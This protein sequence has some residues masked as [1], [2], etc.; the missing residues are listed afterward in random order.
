M[1]NYRPV[2]I[3][4]ESLE[5]LGQKNSTYF[6]HA[7]TTVFGPLRPFRQARFPSSE[8]EETRINTTVFCYV[9]PK[10]PRVRLQVARRIVPVRLKPGQSENAKASALDRGFAKI[11][12]LALHGGELEA[13]HGKSKRQHPL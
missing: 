4:R 11:R 6:A 2:R 7:E 3:D 13:I 12:S 9:A 5:N 8:S 10:P 1:P